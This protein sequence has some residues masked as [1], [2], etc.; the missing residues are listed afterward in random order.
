MLSSLVPTRHAFARI[1]ALAT[2]LFGALLLAWLSPGGA[3]AQQDQDQDYENKG[4]Y[5]NYIF[6]R[7][8]DASEE[9]LL[10][11]GGRIYDMWW[12]VLFQEPPQTTHPAYPD[13]G[14]RSGPSTW[15]CVACHG[16]DY[17]GNKGAFASGPDATGIKGVDAMAGADPARIAEIVRNETHGYTPAMIPDK[18]LWALAR[19]VS[20]GVFSMAPFIDPGTH[21]VRG[22]VERGRQIYQNVCAICHDFDGLAWI[23]GEDEDSLNTLAASTAHNPW[24]AMHKVMNGQT[25]ADMPAL[26]VFGA[27]VVRDVLAYAQTLPKQ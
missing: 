14:A 18:P 5:Q 20:K 25:Y 26:R 19:F 27:E 2:W 9:W 21:K 17:R 16:W 22:N 4:F 1:P 12:G 7:P 24:R 8:D 23:T 11:Y 3:A 10:A 15:R 6:G 13:S